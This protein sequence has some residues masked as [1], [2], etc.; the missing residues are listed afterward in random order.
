MRFREL[1]ICLLLVSTAVLFAADESRFNS[2][3]KT[4]EALLKSFFSG[5]ERQ[6]REL[7]RKENQGEMPSQIAEYFKAATL[8]DWRSVSNAYEEMSRLRS[9]EAAEK[10]DA[11]FN[12]PVWQPVSETYGAWER[13]ATGD[14]TLARAFG[15]GI[16][17]SLPAGCVYFGGTDAGRF[18]VTALMKSHQDGNPF[19][20]VTQNQLADVSYLTYLQSM[21]EGKLY[22]P[23][24]EDSQQAFQEY[25]TDAQAR[26]TKGQLRPGEDVRVVNNRVQVSGQVAV[27]SISALLAKII[28]D[29]NPAKEFFVEESYPL[30][31]MYPHLTPHA[32]ILKINREA[33]PELTEGVLKKDHEFWTRQAG[34]LIGN[35]ITYDT[36]IAD[37]TAFAERTFLDRNYKTFQ[38]DPAFARDANA[39]KAFAKLRSSIAG[40]Y[41][42]RLNQFA[43][44]VAQIEARQKSR[45]QSPLTA[46]EQAILKVHQR[47]NREAEFAFKQAYALCP[48][49][50]EALYRYVQLLA[51]ARR[52]DEA[53]LLAR[54]ARKIDSSE[55]HLEKLIGELEKMKA[56]D[57]TAA[58]GGLETLEADHRRD[59]ADLANATLLI[60][61]YASLG[62][63]GDVLRIA[64]TFVAN[65]QSGSPAI[66]FAAQVYQQLADYPRLE[67]ALARWAKLVAT[68]EAWLDHAASQAVQKK[69]KEA[70]TT[71]QQA[72]FMNAERLKTNRSAADIAPGLKEDARFR[73]LRSHADF[74]KLIGPSR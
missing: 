26:L 69:D 40:I 31:W 6:A 52:F 41:A 25:M 16:I 20:L 46:E 42:W 38:G 44:R 11:R 55:R 21:F 47:M 13:L 51:G 1:T 35:W 5:K 14:Q 22:T 17:D 50:P 37:I 45:P 33:L 12:L 49:S 71:L 57:G 7:C 8:S 74:Q 39:Q 15:Q 58:N 3:A 64:D 24:A 34:G 43:S 54:T 9:S 59:P 4:N 32:L 68:P 63:T 30:E 10:H 70:I 61:K 2:L 66:S 67:I 28:F 48:S 65:P 53:V 56:S 73:S 29:R 18:L 72:L 19:F 36:S 27:M 60:Q 23:G 62:R